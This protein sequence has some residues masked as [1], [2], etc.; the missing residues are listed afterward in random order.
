MW[1]K[2]DNVKIVV[3]YKE[4]ILMEEDVRIYKIKIVSD[5]F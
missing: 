2:I 1:D 4:L 3:Q 5:I